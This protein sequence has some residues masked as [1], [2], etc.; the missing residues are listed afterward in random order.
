MDYKNSKVKIAG[1]GAGKTFSMAEEILQYNKDNN[2]DKDVIA[3]TYTNNAKYN[4]FNNI[5][6]QKHNFPKNIIINTVHSF[7]LEYIVY[8][9]SNYIL[10]KFYTKATSIPLSTNI[11][12]KNKRISELEAQRIIHNEKVFKIA[13]Q[14]IVP[15]KSDKLQI[16]RKKAVVLEHLKANISAIFVDE[17]Q[18]L[19]KDVLELLKYL[20]QN[21]IYIYMIGDP[22]QALKYP[23]LYEDFA[24]DIKKNKI[25]NFECLPNN[26]ITRRLPKTHVTLSNLIC[27]DTQ[28]QITIKENEGIIRYIYSDEPNFIK[29]YN[30]FQN[31]QS[32]CYIKKKSILFNTHNRKSMDTILLKQ[33]LKNKNNGDDEDAFLFEQEQ[34]LFRSIEENTSIKKGLNY[35]LKKNSINLEKTEYA[36]L[37]TS[38]A[39]VENKKFNVFSIDKIKGLERKYCMFILDDSLLEYLFKIKTTYNKEMNYLYVGLTR[40]TNTLLLVID[41][42]TLRKF[43]KKYIDKKMKQLNIK[44]YKDLEDII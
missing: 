36:K 34:K 1:A 14:I 37:I 27:K 22:K 3:I 8:P 42:S 29:V 2:K 19:D 21:K 44:K 40:S 30:F 39:K 10:G 5:Y 20:G 23:G 18:D 31:E 32:I 33:I 15:I 38:L 13:K 6:K 9:Y 35:Y 26:I 28:K 24:I 12:F 43:D 4:I 41:T 11:I 7:L 25:S 16:K 17:S